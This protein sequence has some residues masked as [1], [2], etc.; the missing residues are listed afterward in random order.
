MLSMSFAPNRLN[1][2]SSITSKALN[3]YRAANTFAN[4]VRNDHRQMK[5]GR[6]KYL[7]DHTNSSI[8]GDAVKKIGL[9]MM[10]AIRAMRLM[11]DS[12]PYGGQV[13]SRLIRHLYGA[14]VHWNA[15]VGVGTMIIHGNGLV[16]SGSANIGPDC[17]LAHNATIGAAYDAMTNINGAPTLERGVHVGPGAILLGPI[18][19]GE[20]SKIMAGSVLAHSVLPNSLVRPAASEVVQ[21]NS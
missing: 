1:A 6:A 8:S 5:R 12:V 18:T 2:M 11:R 4:M 3:T 20:G 13:A 10:V 16:I 15:E 14:E 17:I 21:R 19:V 7:A 9:Q